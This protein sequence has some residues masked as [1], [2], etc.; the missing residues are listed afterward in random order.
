MNILI[1]GSG[2]REHT[3]LWKMKQSPLV[4]QIYVAP[5]NA[6]MRRDAKCLSIKPDDIDGLL[7]AAKSHGI[8]LTVVGPELPLVEG[9]TDRF[10]AEGL[11]VFGPRKAAAELEGSKI[12]AKELM[13]QSGVPTARFK[14]FDSIEK[15]ERYIAREK[16]PLVI[17]ADG[18]AAGKGV[19]ISKTPDEAKRAV[20]GAMRERIFGEAGDRIIIEECL[21]GEEFSV[22]AFTDGENVL[23]LAS[24][25]DHKRAYDNDEGPNTGGMGAY[26]PCPLVSDKDIKEAVD[27]TIKPIVASLK[28]DGAPYKGLIYAGLMMT[29]KGPYVLEFNVRFGDP[30]T[31]S[32]LPRLKNDIVPLMLETIEGKLKTRK[33]EWDPRF[34]VSVVMASKG[35]PGDYRKGFAIRGLELL[36]DIEDIRVFHAGTSLADNGEFIT[37]GGRV[38][39]V[40]ALGAS[41]ED[42]R[43][44]AYKAIK[45]IKC[46]NLFYRKDI[47]VRALK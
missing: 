26:S 40:S 3:I 1:I 20:H 7:R 45:S 18:L 15:A 21:S 16:F 47:G 30:E 11:K 23:P 22:L 41:V 28:K 9:I 13:E 10:E 38:L 17:K 43:D 19:I 2:G 6:G 4:R 8:D 25:Q 36:E 37:N 44:K 34:C 12:F 32:I 33:L 24:S 29:Q 35:Y 5:G 46:D 42:A 14:I 27:R 39:A 31:Q